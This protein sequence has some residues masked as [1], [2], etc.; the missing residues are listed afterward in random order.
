MELIGVWSETLA[1]PRADQAPTRYT[2]SPGAQ[3]GDP[4]SYRVVLENERTGSASLRIV[5]KEESGDGARM[6]L[7]WQRFHTSDYRGSYFVDPSGQEVVEW[8]DRGELARARKGKG[9]LT[10]TAGEHGLARAAGADGEWRL[11]YRWKREQSA[12]LSKSL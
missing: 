5:E 6:R 7:Q 4:S 11:K 8:Y 10:R 2:V 9:R 3:N 1:L 12:S